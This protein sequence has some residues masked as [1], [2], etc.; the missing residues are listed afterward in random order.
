MK[1]GITERGDASLDYAW[2][3]KLT[4]HEVDGCILITKNI[5][6]KF[7]ERVLMASVICPIIVHGT[8][9]GWGGTTV[10]PRVLPYKEQ[11]EKMHYLVEEGFPTENCVLRIDP[12]FPTTNGLKRVC[13]VIDYAYEINVLPAAR[14]RVSVLD[15]Y[16]HIKER[17]R[18]AGFEPLYGDKFC[19]KW[20]MFDNVRTTLRRY[21]L[22]F[23]TCAELQLIGGQFIQVGC[24]SVKDL[25]IMGLPIPDS[26]GINGQN[27]N[28]CRCLTMKTELLES[29]KRC[30]NGCLYCYWKD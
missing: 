5:T 12:I 11:L 1:I 25:E 6:D 3:D 28:G 22:W 13:D 16:R 30:A 29:R 14:V 9:T 10:E 4:N 23:E 2:Y 24:V 21:N 20:K 18:K 27:R 8:C 17:F 26:Y 15:E 19:A 7:I